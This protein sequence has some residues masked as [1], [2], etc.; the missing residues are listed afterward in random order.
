M[1][2]MILVGMMILG[3]TM[4]AEKLKT[5]GKIIFEKLKGFWRLKE[6]EGRNNIKILIENWN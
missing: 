3:M 6:V 1:K 2:K 5:D 4:F